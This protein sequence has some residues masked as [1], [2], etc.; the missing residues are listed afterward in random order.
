MRERRGGGEHGTRAHESAGGVAPGRT[1]LTGALQLRAGGDGAAG[2]ERSVAG[3]LPNA[4]VGSTLPGPLQAKMENAFDFSFAQVRVHE[5]ERAASVGALAYTEGHD[6]H[7]AP[8]QYDPA[9]SSGQELIGHELA[10]VVQQ[11]EGRVAANTQFKGVDGNDDAGLEREADDWGARAARGDAVR[12]GGSGGSGSGAIQRR[13]VQRTPQ[14]SHSGRFLDTAYAE[15]TNGCTMHLQFEPGATVDATKIGL[16]QSVKTTASGSAIVTD[17][18]TAPRQVGSGPG[19]GFE[20]DRVA[21]R[22]DPIYGSPQLGAGR[23]LSDTPNHAAGASAPVLGTNTNYILGHH[24]SDSSGPHTKNAELNDRPGRAPA[25]NTGM[26]FE[27]TAL[28]IEGSQQGTYYGSV[29]WGWQ[30]DG[31]GTIT[32]IPFALVSMGVPSQ[33]FLAAAGQWNSATAG[34]TLKARNA[35][36]QMYSLSG[37]TFTAS[38]TVPQNTTVISNG[39]IGA[40]AIEYV[41]VTVRG[42][43]LNGTNGFIRATDLA[44]QGDGPATTDLP[45]PD[46][47]T[48]NA[49]QEINHDVPGPW[50]EFRTLPAGTRVVRTGATWGHPPP[51]KV[52]IRV[53]DGAFIGAEGYVDGTALT[54]ERP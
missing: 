49:A 14:P 31:S 37:A 35:P 13:V 43:A 11:S 47:H 25:P 7:F 2:D 46:V 53:V 3:M 21:G 45:V 32:K 41:S 17:P 42:G 34:G 29:K 4:S 39:T 44:D 22:N 26:E 27:T 38:I 12:R 54:D 48:L 28:A 30:A 15:T 52:W 23:G 24:F 16:T 33:N 8:G 40:G 51:G 5:G 18:Q 20:I 6:L 19:A 9:S 50:R 36:T 1:T 10:H